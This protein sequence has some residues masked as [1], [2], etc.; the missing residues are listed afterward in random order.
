MRSQSGCDRLDGSEK[1]FP[2]LLV[3]FLPGGPLRRVLWPDWES[4]LDGGP[5]HRLRLNR[6]GSVQQ[7][8]ALLHTGE[9]EAAALHGGV[10]VESLA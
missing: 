3:A 8:D 10:E 1:G 6:D 5:A 9:T 2:R 7:P 4:N